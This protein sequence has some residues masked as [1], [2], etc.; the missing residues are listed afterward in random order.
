MALFSW[1]SRYSVG[2][3]G[4]DSQHQRLFELLNELHNGMRA[5]Y[6]RTVLLRIL[7]E[8]F[9][10]TNQHFAEEERAM[11]FFSYPN[12]AD[13]QAQHDMLRR[14]VI[15]Y[16]KECREGASKI[17]VE[18]VNFGVRWLTHHILN[19]DRQYTDFFSERDLACMYE[20]EMNRQAGPLLSSINPG[21]SRPSL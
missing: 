2:I 13:H 21:S 16:L 18:I 1:E 8:L 14:Q 9:E 3:A 7:E 12:A 4:W 5:G 20:K 19:T 15:H 17:R 6:G 10:Y 11:H